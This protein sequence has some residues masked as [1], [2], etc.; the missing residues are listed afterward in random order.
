LNHLREASA[1]GT[2]NIPAVMDL[3]RILLKSPAENYEEI[4]EAFKKALNYANLTSKNKSELLMCDGYY[5]FVIGNRDMAIRIW[6]SRLGVRE[7]MD[8]QETH[9]KAFMVRIVLEG[10][11]QSDCV[12]INR[13]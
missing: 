5:Q 1:R 11:H 6:L 4:E 13:D 12:S 10:S 8:L 7:G 2:G 3:L 9:N